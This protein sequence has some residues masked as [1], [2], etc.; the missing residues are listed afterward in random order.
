MFQDHVSATGITFLHYQEHF[1][2]DEIF[3]NGF[4]YLFINRI[5]KLNVVDRGLHYDLCQCKLPLM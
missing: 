3:I 4:N 2:S 5:H 1:Y